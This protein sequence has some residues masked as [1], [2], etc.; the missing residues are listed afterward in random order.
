MTNKDYIPTITALSLGALSAASIHY[1]NLKLKA[2]ENIG[3]G[4]V[5]T[6]FKYGTIIFFSG[7]ALAGLI[8]V[9]RQS[10]TFVPPQGKEMLNATSNFLNN[11][12]NAVTKMLNPFNIL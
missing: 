8:L 7:I 6:A 9:F 2:K 1:Y 12:L 3:S 5:V 10:L 11:G 4:E